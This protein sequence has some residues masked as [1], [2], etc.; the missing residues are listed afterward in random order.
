MNKLQTV[1]RKSIMISWKNV[2]LQFSLSL[3][4]AIGALLVFQTPLSAQLQWEATTIRQELALGQETA[5]A[6]F[7]FENIGNYPI[8]IRETSSSCGC[9]TA[10]L[11]RTTY[12]PGDKGVIIAQFDVGDRTGTRRNT[13]RVL[14]DDPTKPSTTLTFSVEI[15]V[16]IDISPRLVHWRVG[17]EE[18]EKLVKIQVNPDAP[19]EISGIEADRDGFEIELA[20]SEKAGEYEVR[21]TPQSTKTPERVIISLQTE[22]NMENRRN[23]SFYAYVR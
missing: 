5:E 17:E 21:V 23:L 3:A 9:T 15:P 10:K 19:F 11:E 16:L 20:N 1:A 6:Q 12:Y 22:P 8:V 18:A 2:V 4:I 14:T 13:V 7:E